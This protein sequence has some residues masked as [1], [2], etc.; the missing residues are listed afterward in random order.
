MQETFSRTDHQPGHKMNL[1][2]FKS[3]EIISSTSS[4]HK[5]IKL[6]LNYRKK[7]MRKKNELHGD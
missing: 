7:E 4:D 1:N 3:I 5:G 2:K 6:E